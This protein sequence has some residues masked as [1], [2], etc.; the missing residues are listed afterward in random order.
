MTQLCVQYLDA[1]ACFWIVWMTGRLHV[2]DSLTDRVERE[3]WTCMFTN[4]YLFMEITTYRIHSK[5]QH[6]ISTHIHNS[7]FAFN[8]FFCHSVFSFL[9]S[10]LSFVLISYHENSEAWIVPRIVLPKIFFQWNGKSVLTFDTLYYKNF[11]LYLK[12]FKFRKVTW[13]W[14][15]SGRIMRIDR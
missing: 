1:L 2:R 5:R 6:L 15:R 11:F 14:N 3:M 8:Q 4:L 12:T 10:F 13:E 9:L 7:L